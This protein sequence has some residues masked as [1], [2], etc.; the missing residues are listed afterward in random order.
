VLSI[1]GSLELGDICTDLA[2]APAEWSFGGGLGN[3]HVHQVCG[4]M[5]LTKAGKDLQGSA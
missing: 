4:C 3:C 1:R 2:A 5:C